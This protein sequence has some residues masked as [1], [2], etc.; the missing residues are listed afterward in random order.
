MP[1]L[2]LKA[3]DDF[4]QR[5]HGPN[6]ED[7]RMDLWEAIRTR[8]SV[9][10]YKPEPLPRE[11]IEKVMEADAWSRQRAAKFAERDICSR[12]G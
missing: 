8:R 1:R 5:P 4:H 9:R 12:R 7:C 6:E 10:A 3:S 2:G 11:L